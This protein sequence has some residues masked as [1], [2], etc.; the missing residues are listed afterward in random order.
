MIRRTEKFLQ[1]VFALALE[2]DLGHLEFSFRDLG[3]FIHIHGVNYHKRP[4]AFLD[5]LI[6]KNSIVS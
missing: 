1:R 6:R 2:Q 4:Q 3:D 5:H